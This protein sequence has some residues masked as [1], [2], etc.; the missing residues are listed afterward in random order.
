MRFFAHMQEMSPALAAR[1]TQLDYNREMA[2]AAF[3]AAGEDRAGLG[4]ARLAADPD[5]QSAEFAIALRADAKGRGLGRA[6]MERIIA[7]AEKRG[8][9]EIWGDVLAGNRPMLALC[10]K[11]GFERGRTEDG[12]VR[13]RRRLDA[14]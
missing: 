7:V 12:I 14:G 10:E 6:L 5:N 3:P 4:V 9:G 2:L 8:I 13:V 11:L 1:L